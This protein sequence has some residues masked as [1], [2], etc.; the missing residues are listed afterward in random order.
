MWTELDS[1]LLKLQ[2]LQNVMNNQQQKERERGNVSRLGE[3]ADAADEKEPR[4][5]ILF[6]L[7][8]STAFWCLLS[9]ARK[10]TALSD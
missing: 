6:A 8:C 3:A 4:L 9:P 5:G 7:P 10:K 2:M 1:S